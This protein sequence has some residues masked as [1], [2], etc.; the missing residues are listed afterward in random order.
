MSAR[1]SQRMRWRRCWC[2]E[3]SV[4]SMTQ[5]SRPSPSHAPS[6]C[7]RAA[8]GCRARVLLG[9]DGGSRSG[10]HRR[11]LRPTARPAHPPTHTRHGLEQ[12]QGLGDVVAVAPVRLTASG[13]PPA[14]VRRWCLLPARALSTGLAPVCSPLVAPAHGSSRRRPA[15]SRSHRPPA[16]A[17][18][19]ARAATSTPPPPASRAGGASR[20][21][22]SRS[23]APAAAAPTRS[24]C[25]EG[26]GSR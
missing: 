18:G 2:S 13:R 17:R 23:R 1:R 7:G 21:C 3:L 11:E 15:S 26:T 12:G 14:S 24:R 8:G 19:E 20:S 9:G 6:S 5:R 25:G 4:R 10:G 22:P 16:G